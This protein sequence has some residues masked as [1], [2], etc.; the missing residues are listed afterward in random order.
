[1]RFND[2]MKKRE[3][4]HREAIQRSILRR[5]DKDYDPRQTDISTIIDR[6]VNKQITKT[7]QEKAIDAILLDFEDFQN[8]MGISSD[9]GFDLEVVMEMYLSKFNEDQCRIIVQAFKDVGY[10]FDFERKEDTTNEDRF[11]SESA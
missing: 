8:E 7:L 3:I 11:D 6:V 1:M 5:E 2:D 9:L 10:N 4:E